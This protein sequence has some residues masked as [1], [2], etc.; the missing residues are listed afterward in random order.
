MADDTV[1]CLARPSTEW[2]ANDFW[3]NTRR[4]DMMMIIVPKSGDE[5]FL[6]LLVLLA[7]LTPTTTKKI[8]S[9]E[10]HRDTI[11]IETEAAIKAE[12]VLQSG[13]VEAVPH[14]RKGPLKA[15]SVANTFPFHLLEMVGKAL[16]DLKNKTNGLVFQN[17]VVDQE[18]IGGADAV[19]VVVRQSPMVTPTTC[20]SLR[21]TLESCDPSFEEDI[22]ALKRMTKA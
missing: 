13:T 22:R 1:L 18:A 2:F 10:A 8:G 14:L 6:P 17:V 9:V 3:P 19:G 11:I 12:K 15:N 21:I 20:P 4:R 7:N 16:T 5:R